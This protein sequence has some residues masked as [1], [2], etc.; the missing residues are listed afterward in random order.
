MA[1]F[2]FDR[3]SSTGIFVAV[4]ESAPGQVTQVYYVDRPGHYYRGSDYSLG[5][6]LMGGALTGYVLGSTLAWP[7]LFWCWSCWSRFWLEDGPFFLKVNLPIVVFQEYGWIQK[8]IQLLVNSMEWM[9]TFSTPNRLSTRYY[10]TVVYSYN[11]FI[12]FEDLW[13][14]W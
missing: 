5:M 12:I 13:R 7:L 8:L 2:L 14:L 9:A 1:V 4:Y 6:G 10:G 11:S 3:Y